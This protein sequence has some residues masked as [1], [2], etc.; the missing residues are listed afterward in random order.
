MSSWAV[1]ARGDPTV[2]RRPRRT[3]LLYACCMSELRI[4]G[5]GYPEVTTK[6][7][8]AEQV[9]QGD[10]GVVGIREFS[11]HDFFRVE[12]ERL[13]KSDPA[14]D[15]FLPLFQPQWQQ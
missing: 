11:R 3:A 14:S 12:A 15:P 7:G 13:A 5:R 10:S 8:F 2:R 1:A 9:P 4:Q 6:T